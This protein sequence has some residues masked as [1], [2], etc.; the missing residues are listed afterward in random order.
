MRFVSPRYFFDVQVARFLKEPHDIQ[1]VEIASFL[2]IIIREAVE[3]GFVGAQKSDDVK[4]QLF[5][6]YPKF[7][8]FVA[9]VLLITVFLCGIG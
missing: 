6:L 5:M 2:I 3:V 9:C 7:I 8:V 4:F 1:T